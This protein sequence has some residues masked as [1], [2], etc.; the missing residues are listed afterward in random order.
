[1]KRIIRMLTML[2]II[3]IPLTFADTTITE[4]NMDLDMTIV[5]KEIEAGLTPDNALY[6]LDRWGEG[7]SLALTFDNEKKA[8]KS[9]RYA[10]ERLAELRSNDF[11]KQYSEKDIADL[12][13]N[14]EKNY[15]RH[16]KLTQSSGLYS[17]LGEEI[18]R[19]NFKLEFNNRNQVQSKTQ[20]QT[21]SQFSELEQKAITEFE[22]VTLQLI[23]KDNNNAEYKYYKITK[24]GIIEFTII[25]QPDYTIVVNDKQKMQELIN[26]YNQ[27]NNIEYSEVSEIADIPLSLKARVIKLGVLG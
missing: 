9:L 26:R 13:E 23:V 24:D 4:P 19:K 25:E 14:F 10:E 18:S 3:S 20:T 21:Q 5:N 2:M 8:S 1:M 17:E 7:I 12:E 6:F 22:N 11:E 16:Y 27:G 15:N